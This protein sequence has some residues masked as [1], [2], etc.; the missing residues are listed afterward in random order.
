MTRANWSTFPPVWIVAI[1]NVVFRAIGICSKCR[2]DPS[3][4]TVFFFLFIF[5]NSVWWPWNIRLHWV[6]KMRQSSLSSPAPLW[7]VRTMHWMERATLDDA[8]TFTWPLAACTRWRW[9]TS[10]CTSWWSWARACSPWWTARRGG[11]GWRDSVRREGPG[12]PEGG[13]P[14]W[15]ARGAGAEAG[16]EDPDQ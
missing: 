3:R 14:C 5:L 9:R 11:A 6:K 12:L 15:A 7:H 2:V 16:W 10:S 8:F 13:P 4:K 1:R